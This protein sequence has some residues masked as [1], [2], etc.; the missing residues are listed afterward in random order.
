MRAG[1]PTETHMCRLFEEAN[2]L[3]GRKMCV[4][5]ERR[6]LPQKL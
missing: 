2:S 1:F 5:R 4:C 3:L 6:A